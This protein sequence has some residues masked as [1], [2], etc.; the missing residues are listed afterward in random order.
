MEVLA[1]IFNR[2]AIKNF[3]ETAIDHDALMRILEAGRLSPS[4]KNRQ[5]W[6]FIIID[7]PFIKG[8]IADAA[9]NQDPVVSAPLLI[10]LCTT[11]IDYKMP[12]GQL[13]YPIDLG[14]AGAFMMLQAA[15]EG[16][17]SCPITTFDAPEVCRILTIPYSMKVVMLL[18]IGETNEK[19][20]YRER[21]PLARLYSF[22]TW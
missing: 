1:E 11:N 4:A 8:Q 3:C 13:S 19:P 16:L 20:S 7:D 12:N 17:G 15:H 9:Y 2:Y 10:A 14:I 21:L 5:S 18:A 6:R 22:N